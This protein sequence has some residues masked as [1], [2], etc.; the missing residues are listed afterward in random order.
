M[1][2]KFPSDKINSTKN[3]LFSFRELQLTTVL[4]L[5]SDSYMSWRT[6]FASLKLCVGL[7]FSIRFVFIKVQIFIQ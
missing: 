2:K 1:L 3:A 5:I 6:R 7:S 4:L